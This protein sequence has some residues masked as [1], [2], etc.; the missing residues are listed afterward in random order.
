MNDQTDEGG[1][2]CTPG[3][4]RFTPF[5]MGEN[6]PGKS[7][8]PVHVL[9]AYGDVRYLLPACVCDAFWLRQE[10]STLARSV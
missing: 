1:Y 7:M 5:Y 2:P 4:A 9:S 10:G 8:L 6:M 3:L